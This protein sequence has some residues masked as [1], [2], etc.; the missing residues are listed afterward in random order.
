MSAPSAANIRKKLRAGKKLG[1]TELASARA[2][3]MV[4]RA[5][6]T[7]RKSKKYASKA[8]GGALKPVPAGNKGLGKLPKK[9]RNRM[10]FMKKGGLVMK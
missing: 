6:G 5:D 3:G 8:A 7:K 1:A 9:V 10:G 4:K 2:R